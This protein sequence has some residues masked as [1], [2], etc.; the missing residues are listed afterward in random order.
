MQ[1]TYLLTDLLPARLA[2]DLL[3]DH[4]IIRSP[5]VH[6]GDNEERKGDDEE[7]DDFAQERS[8]R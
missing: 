3:L 8:N 1:A 5:A 4:R 2:F 6:P 7:A